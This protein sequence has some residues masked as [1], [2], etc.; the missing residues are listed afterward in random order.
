DA[1]VDYLPSPLDVPPVAGT[2]PDGEEI[3]ARR[4]DEAEPFAALVFK[5][6]ADP[7]VGR[8]SYFRVY[9]GK[10]AAG[11][12]AYNAT[13]GQRE[14]IGRL[15][16][17]HANHREDVSEV[18]AGDI[19]A[20]VGLKHSTTGD[21]LCDEEHPI[22]LETIKFPEPVISVAIEPATKADMDK[23][24]N[25]LGRLAEEDPTFRVRT[26]PETGQTLIWGMGELHLE[27]IVDRMMREFK[28]N[29]RV[30]TPEVAYRETITRPARAEGRFVRQT[31]GHGQFGDVWIE[32]EP[33]P[34]GTGFEFVNKVVGG[35]I[36]KE[37]IPAVGAGAKEAMETGILA[38]YPMVDVRATLVDGDY[39][40]VDSSEMAFKIAGSMGLKAAASKAGPQL[41]EP[42][43]KVEVVMPEESL[44]DVMGDLSS[45]RA[46]IHGIEARGELQGVRALV[47]LAE[48]FG[49]ATEL[50]S[51]TSGRGTYTMEFGH[52]EAVPASVSKEIM[53][54]TNRK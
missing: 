14:R 22:V 7:F 4:A 43:M 12:Y 40:E 52:Y 8:L 23:M 17:M 6:V 44:G 9:S 5:I 13:K 34:A 3:E 18:S 53:E 19:A 11:S 31:G 27:V 41:L 26:D 49:Y 33:L 32:V 39:H 38:G 45:R 21:T 28:V 36:P 25:A 37:Y 48:M 29:A 15:L 20:V 42:M 30:G 35:V 1:V 2:Q 24:G 54:K 16:K 10:L 50:R 47:P 51:M 46:Q